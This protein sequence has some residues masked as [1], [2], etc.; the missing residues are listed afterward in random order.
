M[1]KVLEGDLFDV[2]LIKQKFSEMD[3]RTIFMQL[4]GCVPYLVG[5]YHLCT[6]ER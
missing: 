2:L 3:S 5:I 6:T 4:F 1:D